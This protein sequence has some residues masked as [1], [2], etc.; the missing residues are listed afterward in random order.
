MID[1]TLLLLSA[2]YGSWVATLN[3]FKGDTLR[4]LATQ[5]LTLAEKQG[6]TVPLLVGHRLMGNS[7]LLTGGIAEGRAHLDQAFALYEPVQHRP[8]A[9]RFGQEIGVAIQC[10]RSLALWCLGY[11]EAA[12]RDADHALT[13]AREMDQAATLMFALFF[14]SFVPIFRG[15][16]TAADAQLGELAA[17]ADEKG[18][19]FWEAQ[20]MSL[21]AASTRP[22]LIGQ[23][24]KCCETNP[25]SRTCRA[26]GASRQSAASAAPLRILHSPLWTSRTKSLPH[27]PAHCS[28]H[29]NAGLLGVIYARPRGSA[30][31]VPVRGRTILI[32]VNSPGWVSTSID[33][34]CC[35]TMMS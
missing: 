18:S 23:I 16:Y 4:E 28:A 20:G 21:R 26:F 2:L 15:H 3:A 1:L 8:L 24:A 29:G 5:V 17:L 19:L 13:G 32:S 35:L 6:T 27:A 30:M 7:L 11:P 25:V 34:E 31:N 22:F 9:M 12:L 14:A 10:F 33:P